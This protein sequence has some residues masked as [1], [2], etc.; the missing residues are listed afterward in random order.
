MM[1]FPVQTEGTEGV[2]PYSDAITQPA[3]NGNNLVLN[4][5]IN[6]QRI[7]EE[8][9]RSAYIQ[10][11]P[12]DGICAIVMNPY[13]GAILAMVSLPDY[14][15]CGMLWTMMSRSITS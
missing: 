13:T 12:R 11:A 8:I 2:L 14:D 7:T 10:Y 15:L 3:V 5:D 4:V 9:C 6:I 1:F